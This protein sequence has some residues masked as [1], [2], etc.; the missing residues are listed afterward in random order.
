MT[1]RFVLA[2]LLAIITAHY[3]DGCSSVNISPP[4]DLL[5]PPECTLS[6]T[7]APIS[8]H[9]TATATHTAP[10]ILTLLTI[11]TPV[12]GYP[13]TLQTLPTLGYRLLFHTAYS[14]KLY[15]PGATLLISLKDDLLTLTAVA[16]SGPKELLKVPFPHS[17]GTRVA[18]PRVAVHSTSAVFHGFDT[19]R[20][21]NYTPSLYQLHVPEKRTSPPTLEPIVSVGF[22]AEGAV[23]PLSK[24]SRTHTSEERRT[25][26]VIALRTE[27]AWLLVCAWCY[28]TIQPIV[29]RPLRT[30]H[31]SL[32]LD[33][34]AS[35]RRTERDIREA[36][37][38]LSEF[39]KPPPSVVH[40]TAKGGW[41]GG[42]RQ[43]EVL[44]EIRVCGDQ[45]RTHGPAFMKHRSP[46][47]S[48]CSPLLFTHACGP[49]RSPFST[50]PRFL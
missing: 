23:Q 8:S 27:R 22:E 33:R 29:F 6:L 36:D 3:N 14:T 28:L 50:L 26:T 31:L 13:L 43:E 15:N 37:L 7:P 12:A 30:P 32:P 34:R 18:V 19:V 5:L 20:L 35:R 10:E 2:L 16:E 42:G 17:R 39:A 47:C 49:Y 48:R 40:S 46:F 45:R 11:T 38:F 21:A 24:V 41:L 25:C 9:F 1:R 4:V 44:C